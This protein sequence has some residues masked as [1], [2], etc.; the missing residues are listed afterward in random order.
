VGL[1]RTIDGDRVGEEEGDGVALNGREGMMKAWS[2]SGSRIVWGWFPGVD[3]V[4]VWVE[5][6]VNDW[7]VKVTIYFERPTAINLNMAAQ[8][9]YPKLTIEDHTAELSN[10]TNRALTVCANPDGDACI[11]IRE[12]FPT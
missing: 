3:L 9:E 6:G 8:S 4:S 12:K 5:V 11:S 7:R 10:S 1:W 2:K